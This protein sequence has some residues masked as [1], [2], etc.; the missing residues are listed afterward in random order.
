[1]G[2]SAHSRMSKEGS[3]GSPKS[4]RQ[5]SLSCA[6]STEEPKAANDATAAAENGPKSKSVVM[7]LNVKPE[8]LTEEQMGLLQENWKEL[9][10]NI[11]KVGVITFIR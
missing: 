5:K 3:D 6:E 4:L 1:M 2:N 8:P 10:D 7:E 11:A 9:E